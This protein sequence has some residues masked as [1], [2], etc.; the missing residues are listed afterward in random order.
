MADFG[1]R[2][3]TPAVQ[4]YLDARYGR[5]SGAGVAPG[6]L[7]VVEKDASTGFW[8][9]SYN[10]TTGAPVYTSG[11]A[12]A[13]VRPTSRTDVIV[14]WK[15]PDPSPAIVTSGTGGM[16]SPHDVRWITP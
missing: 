15:G 8:P 13:G 7:I 10:S 5:A 16:L 3:D 2:V 9:A 11:S 1:Y 14:A 6:D 12:S 4:A